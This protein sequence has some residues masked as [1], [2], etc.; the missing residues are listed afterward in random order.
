[1]DW[2][3]IEELSYEFDERSADLGRWLKEQKMKRTL[4]LCPKAS[5]LGILLGICFVTTAV[6]PDQAMGQIIPNPTPTPTTQVPQQPTGQFPT[7]QQQQQA[8]PQQSAQTSDGGVVDIDPSQAV[9]FNEFEDTRNQG[10]VGATG[11]RMNERGFVGAP[12]AF[13]GTPGDFG[14]SVNSQGGSGGNTGGQRGQTGFGGPQSGFGSTPLGQGAGLQNGF[15][16]QRG[17]LRGA[18]RPSFRSPVVSDDRLTDQFSTSFSQLPQSQ[19]FDGQYQ[20][21][22]NN[23]TA[24]VTGWVNSKAESDHLIAQLRFQPGIYE[25]E[26][27]LEIREQQ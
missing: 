17:G 10:F 21:V 12:S 4:R 16:V 26:N 23:K 9:Q 27:N 15:V 5:W 25:I 7:G 19:M 20:V 3:R 1:M 6:S 2:K 18:V 22:V 24:T 8:G 13:M 14:G 11:T